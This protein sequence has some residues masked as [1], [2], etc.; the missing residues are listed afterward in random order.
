MKTCFRQALGLCIILL[1]GILAGC[2][3][4]KDSCVTCHTD[5]E[6]LKELAKPI[7]EPEEAT[8]EG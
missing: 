6:R 7:E 1:C 8:G 5:K 4:E 3:V 2:V